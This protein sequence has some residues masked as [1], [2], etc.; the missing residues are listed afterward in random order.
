MTT[1]PGIY[2]APQPSPKNPKASK[3][4]QPTQPTPK[5]LVDKEVH[6]MTKVLED[7]RGNW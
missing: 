2:T 7:G 4:P 3:L 6:K 1:M 5:N